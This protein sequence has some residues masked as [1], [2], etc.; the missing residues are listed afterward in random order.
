MEPN[1]NSMLG[2][3]EPPLLNGDVVTAALCGSCFSIVIKHCDRRQPKEE[4]ALAHGF[5]GLESTM[6]GKAWQQEQAAGGITST[7]HRKQRYGLS[8][9]LLPAR[10][11]LLKVLGHH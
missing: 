10:L 7:T 1:L 2:P 11:Y 8:S 3:S 5:R 9:A 6:A 4:F